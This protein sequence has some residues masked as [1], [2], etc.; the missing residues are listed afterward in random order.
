MQKLL[1]FALLALTIVACSKKDDAV[2]PDA[3]SA[4][5]GV[6]PLTYIRLDSA[7]VPYF[8]PYNLPYA[9]NGATVVSGTMTASK[10]S[11]DSV[12]LDVHL[13]VTG[14]PDQN[15]TYGTF[16]LKPSGASYTLNYGTSSTAGTIDGKTVN[17]DVSYSDGTTPVV[18]YRD[19]LI[20]SK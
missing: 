1:F 15:F 14:I 9:Y 2:T 17:I 20:G 12:K 16:Y 4:V 11:V 8:G 3:G 13:V 5:A 18:T 10:V 6:Y 7:A 19:V